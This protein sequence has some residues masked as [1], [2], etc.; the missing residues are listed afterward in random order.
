MA[1]LPF[2]VAFKQG[3]G[4]GTQISGFGSGNLIFWFWFQ[5]LELFDSVSRKIWSK[6]QEKHFII[7]ITYFEPAPKKSGLGSSSTI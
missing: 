7:C 1:R 6:K 4:A 2:R 3:C 5:H